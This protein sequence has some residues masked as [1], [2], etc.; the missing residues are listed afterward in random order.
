MCGAHAHNKA[1]KAPVFSPGR[2]SSYL[3]EDRPHLASKRSTYSVSQYY[4]TC[5]PQ[6]EGIGKFK[7]GNLVLVSPV[8][9]FYHS[10]IT[11]FHK[12]Y[13]MMFTEPYVRVL[14]FSL[15]AVRVDSKN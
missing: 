2:I 5:N 13:Y 14:S 4:N 9:S 3:V 6:M 7:P 15:K 12:F 1:R 8:S 11:P 10:M